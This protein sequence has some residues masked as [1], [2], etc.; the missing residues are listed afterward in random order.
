VTAAPG[1]EVRWAWWHGRWVRV[2]LADMACWCPCAQDERWLPLLMAYRLVHGML[3]A[4]GRP[5]LS[6]VRR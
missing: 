6:F 2:V 1:A 5:A 3:V 4:E